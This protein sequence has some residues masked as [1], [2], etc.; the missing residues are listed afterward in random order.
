MLVMTRRAIG[1]ADWEVRSAGGRKLTANYR[2][3]RSGEE[4]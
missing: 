1:G 3:M 2:V 4:N